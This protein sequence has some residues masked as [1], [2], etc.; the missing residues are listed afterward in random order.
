MKPEKVFKQ[1]QSI[2][3]FFETSDGTKFFTKNLAQHHAKSLE[4]K[5][6]KEVKKSAKQ[7]SP[8]S[9]TN[10]S[11]KLGASERIEAINALETVEAIELA[12]KDETAKTVIAAGEEKIKTINESNQ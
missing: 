2:S 6:V 4:D 3:S 9:K 8:D 7:N 5:A 12:L 10:K 11:I 1:H